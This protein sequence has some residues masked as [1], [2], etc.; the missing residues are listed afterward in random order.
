MENTAKPRDQHRG[1]P[2]PHLGLDH[3][4]KSRVERR[5]GDESG[6]PTLDA[7]LAIEGGSTPA[8]AN[9]APVEPDV[10]NAEAELDAR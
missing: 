9:N 3:Y 5:A 2:A 10:A 1:Q 4:E 7:R 8:K 6:N